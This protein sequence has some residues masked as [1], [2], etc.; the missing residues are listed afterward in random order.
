MMTER[1]RN[2]TNRRSHGFDRGDDHVVV[3]EHSALTIFTTRCPVLLDLAIFGK[4]RRT[5]VLVY[6]RKINGCHEA[7]PGTFRPRRA[8]ICE[9]WQLFNL[10]TGLYSN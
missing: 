5:H 6:M 7:T 8:N 4:G 9:L 2:G 10:V 1:T 3:D